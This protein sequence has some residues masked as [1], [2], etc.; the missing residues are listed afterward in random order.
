MSQNWASY[1]DHQVDCDFD[2]HI[3][4]LSYLKALPSSF[5]SNQTIS[6]CHTYQA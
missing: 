4:I 3:R 6:L 5:E 1:S 2:S